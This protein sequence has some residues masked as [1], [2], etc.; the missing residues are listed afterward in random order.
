MQN[1]K[2]IIITLLLLMTILLAAAAGTYLLQQKAVLEERD[3]EAT[4]TLSATEATPYTDLEGDPFTFADYKGHVRVVNTWASW[5]PFSA[6]ELKDLERL[7]TDY[8][9]QDVVVIAV[10]RKETKEK[11]AAYLGTLQTFS[12]VVFAIDVTDAFYTSVGGYAM[13]E[14]VFYDKYGNIVFHQRGVMSYE[15]MQQ[16]VEAALT[17]AE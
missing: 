16:R 5:S 7:A 2:S 17:A 9:E 8:A 1:K 13:P 14:T 15:E 6:T 11:A 10:N 3:T 4:Q 12:K